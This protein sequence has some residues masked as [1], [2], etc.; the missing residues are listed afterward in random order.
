MSEA[1]QMV[2]VFL[3]GFVVA[4]VVQLLRW[5]IAMV[6]NGRLALLY[7]LLGAT[8]DGSAPDLGLSLPLPLPLP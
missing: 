2:A 5:S 8:L 3:T 4:V 6:E 1:V 7:Y